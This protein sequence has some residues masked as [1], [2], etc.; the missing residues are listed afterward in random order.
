MTN[1]AG[2]YKVLAKAD[3]ALEYIVFANSPEEAKELVL[4][5]NFEDVKV[6]EIL[7]SPGWILSAQMDKGKK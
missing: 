4:G 6:I 3:A 7:D 1:N 5:G 2:Y